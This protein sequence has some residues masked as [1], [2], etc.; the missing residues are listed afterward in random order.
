[1]MHFINLPITDVF[2]YLSLN[3]EIPL[4]PT[5]P[6]RKIQFHSA[7]EQATITGDIGYITVRGNHE[8]SLENQLAKLVKSKIK[9]DQKPDYQ[10]L[11][12]KFDKIIVATG[13]PQTT[14]NL[15]QWQQT[16]VSVKIIGATIEGEF[17]PTTVKMWL[18]NNFAPQGYG[19][20]LPI[21]NK[22]ASIAIAT[23]HDIVDW[24]TLWDKFLAQLNF[25][26]R[27]KDTFQIDHYEIGRAKTQQFDN[28]YIIGHAGGFI[29]PFLGFGQFTSIESGILVAKALVKNKNYNK[30][31]KNLRKDY[32]TS[33]KLR[34]IMAKMNNSQLDKLVKTLNN[35]TVK[36]MFLQ[37]KINVA[38]ILGWLS[39]LLG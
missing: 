38:K 13:D 23:P 12:K 39:S 24:E 17:E 21:G 3:H 20:F 26:F 1:M 27:I 25:D 16:D 4:Q 31:T 15:N 30:L 7:N 11:K 35:N 37:R 2:Y 36:R 18:N 14:K 8:R 29:M 10:Q 5:L 6:I 22:L 34:K 28:T 33:Y 19:Y 9:Y 32:K